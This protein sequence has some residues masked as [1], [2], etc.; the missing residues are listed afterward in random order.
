MRVTTSAAVLAAPLIVAAAPAAHA[1]QDAPR[2]GHSSAYGLAA[3][4]PVSVAATPA[5]ASAGRQPV[6]RSALGVTANPLVRASV[7][8]VSARAGH[9]RASV[10]DV[11]LAK[12]GLSAKLITA[13]CENRNA[14]STLVNA[15]LAGTRLKAAASPN[16]ALTVTVGGI[17]A[18]SVVLNKQ[19]RHANGG[20]TVTAVEITLPPVLGKTQKVSLASATCLPAG[21]RPGPSPSVSRTP[22]VPGPSVGPKAPRLPMPSAPL[23]AAPVPTPVPRD[24]PV[25]G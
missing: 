2:G 19:V 25:T 6:R 11:A 5:V 17:G 16:S 7:L 15:R 12:A 21:A 22:G 23:P 13:K 9:G 10:A 8:R 14:V 24:L 1:A 3:S 4:G 20:V 18:V